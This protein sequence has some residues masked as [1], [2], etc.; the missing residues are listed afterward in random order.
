VVLMAAA[1]ERLGTLIPLTPGGTGI[2]EVGT[3]AWLVAMGVDP[4]GA[5]AGVLL[6]RIFLIV[7]EIPVG[8]V[9]LGGW[10]W[11]RRRASVLMELA[12]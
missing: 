2:A 12:A 7:M 9:L 8:G 10:A 3:I 4:V 5:V 11:R 1:I 6:Y